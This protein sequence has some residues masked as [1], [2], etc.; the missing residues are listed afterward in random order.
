VVYA[1]LQQRVPFPAVVCSLL[2]AAV[3]GVITHVPAGLGVLEAVFVALL[4]HLVP[5]EELL[6]SL[7]I[8]RAMYYLLP[9]MTAT[10]LYVVLEARAKKAASSG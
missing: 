1:L 5:K 7:L 3:A 2:A 4:S 9:L 10:L 6:A 8:Y